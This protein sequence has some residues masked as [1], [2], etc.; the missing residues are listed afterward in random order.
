MLDRRT[1][2]KLWAI[3]KQFNKFMLLC[4]RK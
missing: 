3:F 1:E 4:K 2:E